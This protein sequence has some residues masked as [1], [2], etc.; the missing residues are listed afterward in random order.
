MKK[1]VFATLM[2]IAAMSAKAQVLTSETVN[3][4]YEAVS[5]QTNNEFVFNAEWT[6]KDITTMYVF[7]KSSS[8]KGIVSLKPHLKYEYSYA[9]DGTLNSRTT[10]RW[11]DSQNGWTCAARY[12]FTLAGG[13]YCTEYSRYN[14]TTDSFDMPVEM[15]IYSLTPY[16]SIDCISCYHRDHQTSQFQLVSETLIADQPRLYAEK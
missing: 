15:M 4:V 11:A 3:N 9:T 7:K 14:H 8:P 5:H 12:D 16:D 6:G 10:Y 2:C 1:F 13:K